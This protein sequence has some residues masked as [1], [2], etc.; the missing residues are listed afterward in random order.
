MTFLASIVASLL[1]PQQTA[2]TTAQ[3]PP[4]NPNRLP[5]G[6]KG[7]VKADFGWTDLRSGHKS[8]LKEFIKSAEGHTFVFAGEL[9]TQA[10]H[11]QVQADIIRGLVEAGREVIVGFEMFT[12]PNQSSLAPWTQGWWTPEQ[13]VEK[14]DWK[15][16]WGFDFKLYQPIFEATKQYRLPMLALN[17][18]RDWVRSVSRGGIEG[19]GPERQ[20]EVPKIDVTNKQHR[21]VFDALMGG[22]SMAGTQGDNIYAAQV[23][24]DEAMADTAIKY[25]VRRFGSV[26]KTPS[27]VVVVIVA[28]A[29]H[30]MY[31]QGINWRIKKHTGKECMTVSMSESESP[32]IVSRGIGDFF[33]LAQTPKK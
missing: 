13:F 24:W 27:N 19:L 17:V 14:A 11:H 5:I 18:P 10:E 3:A 9:H 4:P 15:G 32:E 6:I 25:L 1:V 30:G 8:S 12:R 22:H 21:Q 31:E 7:E 20:A 26:D 29:G 33:Y 16:Q 28:G 2:A 23:L